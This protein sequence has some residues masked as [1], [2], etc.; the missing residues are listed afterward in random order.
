MSGKAAG[1]QG[2]Y[3]VF[4]AWLV[5]GKKGY[6]PPPWHPSFLGLSPMVYTTFLGKQGKRVLHTVGPERRVYTIEP[7]TRKTKQKDTRFH[8]GGVCFSLP[9]V[10]LQAG[11]SFRSD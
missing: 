5:P 3:V 2:S 7:Q 1:P 6:T 11:S 4:I 9:W 8:G 10:L